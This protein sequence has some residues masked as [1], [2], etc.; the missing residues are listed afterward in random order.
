MEDRP[1]MREHIQNDNVRKY[2]LVA[3]L[4]NLHTHT[5]YQLNKLD[6]LKPGG[7]AEY[8]EDLRKAKETFE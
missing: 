3:E 8:R 4:E 6:Q 5:G 1:L 2:K 7:V